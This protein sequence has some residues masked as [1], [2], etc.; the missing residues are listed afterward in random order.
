VPGEGRFVFCAAD[1]NI[2]LPLM[3]DFA[4]RNCS[5]VLIPAIKDGFDGTISVAE[6]SKNIPFEIKRVF[7]IYNLVR[8]DNV[9]R[10]K[11]A[12]KT[13]AQVLFCV[14][15]SCRVTLHDGDKQQTVE[16]TEPNRGIYIGPLVWNTLSDFRNNCILLVFASDFFYE[17]DYIRDFNEFLHYSDPRQV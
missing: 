16:L 6:T 11:H 17:K 9:S 1:R 15:G 5:W 14:N 13:L 8:H 4:V 7:Y 2:P 3:N 12:H 10:G